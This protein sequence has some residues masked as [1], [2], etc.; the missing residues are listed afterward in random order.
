MD[1]VA[2]PQDLMLL[3]G[4]AYA[5]HSAQNQLTCVTFWPAQPG[6]SVPTLWTPGGY[7]PLLPVGSL[8]WTNIQE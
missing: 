8:P 7:P 2:G 4:S 5:H 1:S 6:E 3:L